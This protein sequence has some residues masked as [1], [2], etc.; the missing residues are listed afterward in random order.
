MRCVNLLSLIVGGALGALRHRL[1][2]TNAPR[3]DLAGLIRF[4]LLI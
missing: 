3:T 2:R 1:T 4:R